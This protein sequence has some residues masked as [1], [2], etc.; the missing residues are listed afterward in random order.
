MLRVVN[1]SKMFIATNFI[2]ILAKEIKTKFI[3]YLIHTYKFTEVYT[4]AYIMSKLRKKKL[5]KICLLRK[6]LL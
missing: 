5:D 2:Y 1:N 3:Y 4:V 6:T